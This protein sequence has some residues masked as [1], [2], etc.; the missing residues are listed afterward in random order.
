MLSGGIY[1]LRGCFCFD[2]GLRC[3]GLGSEGGCLE[4]DSI[5]RFLYPYELPSIF[6]STVLASFSILFRYS[7]LMF[8]CSVVN[9]SFIVSLLK[10][11]DNALAHFYFQCDLSNTISYCFRVSNAGERR[12]YTTCLKLLY[13]IFPINRTAESLLLLLLLL[14]STKKQH[15]DSQLLCSS[16]VLLEYIMAGE[17]FQILQNPLLTTTPNTTITT[18][19]FTSQFRFRQTHPPNKPFLKHNT[20]RLNSKWRHQQEQ[21]Q[22]LEPETAHT[23]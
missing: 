15:T 22:E 14:T 16:N 19:T 9:L 1:I 3:C 17:S 6:V 11:R 10:E 5:L 23:L 13:N 18:T 12:L 20:N 4:G 7:V 2:A 21:L 8:C